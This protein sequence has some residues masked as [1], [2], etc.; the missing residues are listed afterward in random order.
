MSCLLNTKRRRCYTLWHWIIMCTLMHGNGVG[1]RGIFG[2]VLSAGPIL[3][4][5]Y[6]PEYAFASMAGF[7][8]MDF[9]S[10]IVALDLAPAKE[11]H[12][13][14]LIADS[15]R[16]LTL[17]KKSSATSKISKSLMRHELFDGGQKSLL[18]NVSYLQDMCRMLMSNGVPNN[19]W[20]A[21]S[22]KQ[23]FQ[24]VADSSKLRRAICEVEYSTLVEKILPIYDEIRTKSKCDIFFERGTTNDTED[25]VLVGNWRAI[26][27]AEHLLQR[28]VSSIRQPSNVEGEQM[29]RLSKAGP[30]PSFNK[31]ATS[32]DILAALGLGPTVSSQPSEPSQPKEILPDAVDLPR[33]DEAVVRMYSKTSAGVLSMDNIGI[34][35]DQDDI[36]GSNCCLHTSYGKRK[37]GGKTCLIGAVA[38]PSLHDAGLRWWIPQRYR[39]GTSCFLWDILSIR[40]VDNLYESERHSALGEI[41][42]DLFGDTNEKGTQYSFPLLKTIPIPVEKIDNNSNAS[43]PISLQRWPSEK[44]E[45]KERSKKGSQKTGM[46]MGFSA[47][48]LQDMHLL[49][50]LHSLIPAPEGHPNF[51]LPI[52][53]AFTSA[54]EESAL[55]E[56]ERKFKKNAKNSATTSYLVFEPTPLVMHRILTRS[57]RPSSSIST[58]EEN[59]LI[60]PSILA[61]WFHDLL[62]AMAHCHSNHIVLRTM[63]PDHILIDH[64]GVAKLSGLSR[65]TVLHPDECGRVLDALKSARGRKG[66]GLENTDEVLNNPYIAPELLLGATRYTKESDIWSLGSLM[67]HLLLN[68][69]LFS[70][71]DRPSKIL[72]VLKI[73]GSSTAENYP[74]AT[75]FPFYEEPRKVYKRGVLKALRF[76]FRSSHCTVE[77]FSGP[78]DLLDRMLH[79]DPQK[80]ITATEALEH[81][82]MAQYIENTKSKQF[83]CDFVSSWFS[84]KNSIIGGEE[85]FTAPDWNRANEIMSLETIRK[86][87]N[88]DE[89]TDTREGKRKASSMDA[90]VGGENDDLY[91]LYGLRESSPKQNVLSSKAADMRSDDDELYMMDNLMNP[92]VPKMIRMQ[93]D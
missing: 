17:G 14:Q 60:T 20:R 45:I 46:E 68:K 54:A 11:S 42:Q 22:C 9:K 19:N 56:Y 47:A 37:I 53:V 62:T 36:A 61:S 59:G 21:S 89:D 12:A 71:K 83:Q 80:R 38:E 44:I 28:A 57:K 74:D 55:R 77:D 69:P 24:M 27:I 3:W 40:K 48:A 78:L 23:N 13:A 75:Q 2:Q 93:K 64:S 16:T 10:I 41:T 82:Y 87:R 90:A 76:L 72:A 30:L 73:V 39:R 31:G 15:V 84:M 5:K 8:S 79:L 43:F 35:K 67:A 18:N 85:T 63:H 32:D 34:I 51:V 81:E 26:C 86:K 7:L 66:S 49:H 52:A 91:N 58:H 4:L 65:A 1:L 6:G 50:Q 92:A 29:E 25:I 33:K 70:G 88:R